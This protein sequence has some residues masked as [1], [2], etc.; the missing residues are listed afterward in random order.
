MGKTIQ[1]TVWCK[2]KIL[3]EEKNYREFSKSKFL[4]KGIEF[5]LHLPIV[6]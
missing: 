3:M 1:E 6:I 4:G 2:E 5:L